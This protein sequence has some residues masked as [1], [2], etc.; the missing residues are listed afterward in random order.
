MDKLL[1][2]YS[3]K[4]RTLLPYTL[5]I[6]AYNAF[7]TWM[8]LNPDWKRGKLQRICLFLEELGKTLVKP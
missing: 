8:A 7:V 3:W 4:R 6:S 5:D 2:A 1:S